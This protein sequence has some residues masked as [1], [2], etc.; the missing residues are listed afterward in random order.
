MLLGYKIVSDTTTT[1][2][3]TIVDEPIVTTT[4]NDNLVDEPELKTV[5]FELSDYERWVVEC[6][7]AGEAEGESYNGKILVAQCIFNAALQ[8]GL[9]PS[10]VRE[11]YKYAGWNENPS[12]DVKNAVSEVFDH[13]F[14]IVDEPILYFYA[15]DRVDSEWHETQKHVITEGG[16][17]FFK[18]WED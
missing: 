17:K 11:K 16:H 18:E 4:T 10:Q 14:T 15:P 3:L 9:L 8:D 6:I 13:G 2:A 7:V 12:D 1:D 5:V